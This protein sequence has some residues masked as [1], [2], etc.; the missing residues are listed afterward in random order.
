MLQFTCIIFTH[1]KSYEVFSHLNN[2]HSQAV[3]EQKIEIYTLPIKR[4]TK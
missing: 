4:Y 2:N 1:Q 3:N